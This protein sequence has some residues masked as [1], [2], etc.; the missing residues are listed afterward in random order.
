MGYGSLVSAP[1]L[2]LISA[3]VLNRAGAPP[4]TIEV[5]GVL[6]FSLLQVVAD[7]VFVARYETAILDDRSVEQ[8]T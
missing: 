6:L 2:L 7:G 8:P 4:P 1:S 5:R 3:S